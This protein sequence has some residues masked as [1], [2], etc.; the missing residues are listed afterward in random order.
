MNT[1]GFLKKNQFTSLSLADKRTVV[2]MGP[3]K[4]SDGFDVVYLNKAGK[5]SSVKYCT[6]QKRNDGKSKG[7]VYCVVRTP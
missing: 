4:P 1:I 3:F 6:L 7:V 2:K 5:K